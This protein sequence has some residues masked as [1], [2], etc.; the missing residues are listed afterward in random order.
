MLA[1]G[2]V[3]AAAVAFTASAAADQERPTAG[4]DTTLKMKVDGRDLDFFGGKTV[5]AGD[6][7]TIVNKTDPMEVGLHFVHADQA[8][9]DGR[10]QGAQGVRGAA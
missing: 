3:G 4:E 2:A 7:L 1:L 8:E 5:G 6:K 10:G 9:P